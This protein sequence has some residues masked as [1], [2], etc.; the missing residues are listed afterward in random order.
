MD[1]C[2]SQ[3]DESFRQELRQFLKE[4][5][6]PDWEDGTRYPE[7][8]DWPFAMQMRRKLAQCGWLTMHWPKEYGGQDSLPLRTLIFNEEMAYHRA[9]GRDIFGARMVGPILI[10]FGTEEQKRVFL[11]SI[12]R[13]EVQWCQGYSEA[14]A[15]SDLASLKTTAVEDGNDFVINGGKIWTTLAHRA[16]WMFLL[17]RTDPDAPKHRGLSFLLLDMKSP[18]VSVRPIYDMARIPEFNEVTFDN[19]R[20]SK[21]NLLGEKNKGWHVALTLLDLERSGIEYSATARR[22]LDELIQYAKEVE[23]K[24]TT[25]W[26]DPRVRDILEECAVECEVAR[27]LA[28][29]VAW[30]Q[31]QGMVPSKE[32]SMSKVYGSET[33][34]KVADT[35]M[36]L[37]GLYSQ[38]TRD[39][40][41]AVLKGRVQEIW[42]LSFSSTITAGT[43]EIQRNI[44]ATRG[45]GLPRN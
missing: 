39:S 15:G 4:E 32:A 14:E 20:A 3:E 18:G 40:R 31:A 6:P 42:L 35:G 30:M 22:L 44:I 24:R 45:L 1:F 27:L 36:K 9:P 16:D 19:V 10:L 26:S 8:W 37:L 33:Q 12:A 41:W 38:L 23:V 13:G 17:A 34:Q 29:R 2:F 5:L 43:S 25:L 28:Y 21:G 11:P 7:E